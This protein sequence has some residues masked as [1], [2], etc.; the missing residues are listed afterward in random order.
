M[1]AQ[2]FGPRTGLVVTKDSVLAVR[3]TGRLA[4]ARRQLSDGLVEPHP[5]TAN[6]RSVADLARLAAEVLREVGAMRETIALALPDLAISTL[7]VPRDQ[8]RPRRQLVAKLSESLPYPRTE[9]RY[10]FW[11]G[12]HGEVLGAAVRSSVISQYEDVVEAAECRLGWVDGISLVRIPGWAAESR[13]TE[14]LD[15]QVQ[16]YSDHYC[17]SIFRDGRLVDLRSKLR[18]A[19]DL[20]GVQREV[21]RVPALH[22]DDPVRSLRVYGADSGALATAFGITADDDEDS[23]LESV[24][25]TLLA[26]GRP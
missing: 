6:L 23:H 26:R 8:S 16:M 19:A 18:R 13:D 22:G 14:G 24:L 5:M 12:R 15:I 7:V 1:G 2:G 9:A 25:V 3:R 21:A 11:T 20:D 17:L 10:D 4:R